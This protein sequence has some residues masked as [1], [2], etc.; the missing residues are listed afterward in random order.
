MNNFDCSEE[1]LLK[2]CK[3][4]YVLNR[5]LYWR[6]REVDGF[7]IFLGDKIDIVGV[8][9]ERVGGIREIEI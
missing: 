6:W 2:V 3:D 7:E 5:W 4:K 9:L 8:G 1:K